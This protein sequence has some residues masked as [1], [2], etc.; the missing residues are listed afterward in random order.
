MLKSNLGF[1]LKFKSK[2][3]LNHL[4]TKIGGY[5]IYDI[6]GP[7][8]K[9][10]KH[11]LEIYTAEAVS[12]KLSGKID[13]FNKLNSH[14]GFSESLVLLELLLEKGFIVDFFHLYGPPEIT[15][16][17]YELV[18]DAGQNLDKAPE[19]NG[20]K[21]IFY[22]TAC[23]WKTFRENQMLRCVS[24][25]NRNGMLIKPDRDIEA[26]YSDDYAD[27]ITCFGGPYQWASFGK[28]SKKVRQLNISC[29]HIPQ[30]VQK[31]IRN[32]NK[33][34][35]FGGYGPFHK[36]LDLVIEAFSEL[37]NCE[38]YIMGHLNQDLI[39]QKWLGSMFLKHH[40]IHFKGWLEPQ[41]PE[42]LK[43]ALECDGA[44]FA[45]SS[46][47]G[48]GSVIQCMQFGVIPI[49]NQSTSLP[50]EKNPFE[51]HGQNVE[52]EIA[53]IK[54]AVLKFCDTDIASLQKLSEEIQLFS[55]EHHCLNAYK[56]S[57]EKL[58]LSF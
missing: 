16:S 56:N 4:L 33:F 52:E 9:K 43:L 57:L 8:S 45:S 40:N 18:I 7:A 26:G 42:F 36:G 24:F 37:P 13:T 14:S 39:F 38:L 2:I 20:Q 32:K 17:K 15:W 19:E 10:G 25:Q 35:W 3:F 55:R 53:S 50:T 41:S 23:H 30:N 46:E 27:I 1:R 54:E 48:A 34:I 12:A 31:K 5:G 11:A 28:N 29:T 58:F 49:V 6:S 51:V 22:S 47:G 21:K 44:V